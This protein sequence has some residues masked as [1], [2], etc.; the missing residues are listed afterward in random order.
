MVKKVFFVVLFALWT[1]WAFEVALAAMGVPGLAWRGDEG[2]GWKLKKHLEIE[3]SG[4]VGFL[5]LWEV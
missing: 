5:G 2:C 1:L 4:R 3:L